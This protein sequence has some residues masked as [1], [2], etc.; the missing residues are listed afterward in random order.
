MAKWLRQRFATRHSAGRIQVVSQVIMKKHYIYILESLKDKKNYT[1][2]TSNLE[3]RLSEHTQGMVKST[4][5]RRPL[6][7]IHK[8]EFS[9]KQDAIKREKFLKSRTGRREVKEIKA[10]WPSG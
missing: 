7:L 3:R 9:T 4:R 10:P 8:E 1:G 5:N 2:Y 6:K